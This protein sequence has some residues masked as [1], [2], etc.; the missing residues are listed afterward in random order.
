M[1]SYRLVAGGILW[2][3]KAMNDVTCL[4][5]AIEQGDSSAAGQLLPLIYDQLRK[6][7]AGELLRFA[8]SLATPRDGGR[9]S[10]RADR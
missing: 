6:L 5:S 4:L 7:A 2:W 10:G 1:S 3:L 8:M 9:E